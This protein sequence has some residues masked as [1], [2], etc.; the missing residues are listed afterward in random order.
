MNPILFGIISIQLLLI[1]WIDLQKQKIFNIWPLVNI[2]IFLCLPF[3][4]PEQ[5]HWDWRVFIFPVGF[6]VFG[7]I[8]FLMDIMGAGDSKFLA[9]LFLLIPEKHHF[10]YAEQ[11]LL[12]TILVGSFLLLRT[13]AKNWQKV[14]A[15]FLSR[16]WKGL[17]SLVRSRFSYAPVI[18][19]AWILYGA[20]L[21]S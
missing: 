4:L 16:H 17:F 8:L 2:G 18:L 10:L 12:T 5:Y 1:T 19:L 7:F 20:R 3:V 9:S 15:F 13:I 6:I 11:L 14:H 21:W